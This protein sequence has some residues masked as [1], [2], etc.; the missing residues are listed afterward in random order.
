MTCAPL[1]TSFLQLDFPHISQV[2]RTKSKATLKKLMSVSDKIAH[3]NHERFKNFLLAGDVEGN[4]DDEA[5]D[6]L[7]PAVCA[8]GS[9][10]ALLR[11]KTGQRADSS[12]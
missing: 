2:M 1:H 10:Y 8:P 5:A 4:L 11:N 6:I 9:L 12:S 3:L 7:R